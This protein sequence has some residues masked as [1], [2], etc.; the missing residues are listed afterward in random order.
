MSWSAGRQKWFERLFLLVSFG[1]RF[2][3]KFIRQGG[4][5]VLLAD[6]RRRVRRG[7]RLI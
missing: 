4:S 1:N 7:K 2:L 6:I 3:P 5:H